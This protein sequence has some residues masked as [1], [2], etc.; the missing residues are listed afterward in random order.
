MKGL[1]ILLMVMGH[2]LIFSFGIHQSVLQSLIGTFDMPLFFYASGFLS[3]KRTNDLSSLLK[4]L[5]HRVRSL[6]F[7]W[8]SISIVMYL[9]SGS[10]IVYL[11]TDFY[12]FFYVLMIVS[13]LVISYDFLIK[14]CSNIFI[15]G[16]LWIPFLLVLLLLKVSRLE[17]SCSYIPINQIML[18]LPFFLIGLMC[19]KYKKLNDFLLKNQFIYVISLFLFFLRWSFYDMNNFV[20]VY[21]G[22]LGSICCIQTFFY[23]REQ[24]NELCSLEK[25]LIFLGRNTI[26]IYM[27]NNF[28]IPDLSSI[29]LNEYFLEHDLTFVFI[30]VLAITLIVIVFC[31]LIKSILSTNT[32]LNY[33]FFGRSC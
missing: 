6:L 12:W 29:S 30:L 22:A 26:S 21:M 23:N 8:I 24:K 2:V 3:Y 25:C 18:Y 15:Y 32:Y 11:L 17:N 27:F 10:S 33:A 7:P 14:G 9:F 4:I 13:I 16:V 5:I 1:A 28:F 20:L 19:K 31:L